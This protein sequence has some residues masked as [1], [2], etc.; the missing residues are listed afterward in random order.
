MAKT[1]TRTFTITKATVEG[2]NRT[3]NKPEQVSKTLF[4]EP[5]ND[6]EIFAEF[7]TVNFIAYRVV[8]VSTREEKREMTVEEFYKRSVPCK[9]KKENA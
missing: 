2:F 3:E 7:N 5:E 1:I 4:T 9:E 8:S 6:F